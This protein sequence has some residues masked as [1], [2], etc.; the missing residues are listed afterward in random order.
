MLSSFGATAQKADPGDKDNLVSCLTSWS[1]P[2]LINALTEDNNE[3]GL[4]VLGQAV[5]QEE[6]TLVEKLVKVCRCAHTSSTDTRI[7]AHLCARL[8]ECTVYQ[9]LGSDSFFGHPVP[10]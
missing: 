1:N 7:C 3:F 4:T 5:A 9:G 10:V 6:D 8:L 2:A